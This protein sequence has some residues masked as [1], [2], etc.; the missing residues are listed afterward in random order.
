[1][2][3]NLSPKIQFSTV[4]AQSEIVIVNIMMMRHC[5]IALWWAQ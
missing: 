4:T 2:L 3:E 5:E 1:L